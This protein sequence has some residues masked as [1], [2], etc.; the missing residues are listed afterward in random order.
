L[1]TVP[2][3][4]PFCVIGL[5]RVDDYKGWMRGHIALV[6]LHV[7]NLFGVGGREEIR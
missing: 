5:R 2:P 7:E 3:F 6:E 1:L 4:P